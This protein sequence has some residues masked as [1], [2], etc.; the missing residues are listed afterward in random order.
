MA[1]RISR[2]AMIVAFT[3][4][5]VPRDT[6]NELSNLEYYMNFMLDIL[7]NIQINS[8]RYSLLSYFLNWWKEIIFVLKNIRLKNF[9]SLFKNRL[10]HYIEHI[11]YELQ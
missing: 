9:N 8:E 1:T 3:W 2:P 10:K 7:N 5:S 11:F 6:F 4:R